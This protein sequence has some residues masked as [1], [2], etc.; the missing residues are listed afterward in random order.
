MITTLS[1][2]Q[3]K[4]AR[5]AASGMSRSDAYRAAYKVRKQTRPKSVNQSASR[6]KANV[7]VTSRIAEL[8]RPIVEAA[9]MTLASHLNDL[10]N[11]REKA[12][13]ENQL[14]AAITAEVSRGKAAGLYIKRHQHTGSVE[15]PLITRRIVKAVRHARDD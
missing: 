14:S 15:V 3:E 9:Q 8:R 13:A 11:L 5:A 12:V 6:A 10:L 4:F 1:P 2:Q 7:N